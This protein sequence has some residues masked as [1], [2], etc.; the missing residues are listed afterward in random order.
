MTRTK[1]FIIGFSLSAIILIFVATLFLYK[2]IVKSIPAEEG[3][4]SLNGL[5]NAVEI[6][7]NDYGIPHIFS[8]N[9]HDLFFALGYCTA[10]DRLWQM[11][12]QRRIAQ[13]RLSEIFGEETIDLDAYMRSVGFNRIAS[14]LEKSLPDDTRS[15]LSAYSD[16]V[17]SFI[18]LNRKKLQIEFDILQYEPELWE[19]A[20]SLLL[21]RLFAWQMSFGR[22]C[23]LTNSEIISKVGTLRAAELLQTTVKSSDYPNL[24]NSPYLD[25]IIKLNSFLESRFGISSSSLGNV[26]VIGSKK[27]ASGHPIIANDQHS[28]YTNPSPWYSVSLHSP[29]YDVTGLSLPGIPGVL[30]GSNGKTSWGFTNGMADDCDFYLETLD[31][32]GFSKYFYDNSW[33]NLSVINEK[34]YVK[35]S[36]PIDFTVYQ[37]NRG[38]LI[39]TFQEA[40]NS[41]DYRKENHR[42]REIT[43]PKGK[44]ISIRWTGY[45]TSDE[46]GAILQLNRSKSI[47]EIQEALK[48]IKVPVLNFVFC[49]VS[50]IG[51]MIAGMIP[52]RL[53]SD[54]SAVIAS[55]IENNWKGLE[56]IAEQT[57]VINPT[58]NY[59]IAANNGLTGQLQISS[60]RDNPSRHERIS[61][62]I[63]SRPQ[64]SLED[65]QRIQ[66]DNI[67]F[68]AKKILNAVIPVLQNK[69]SNNYHYNQIITYLNNWDYSVDKSSISATIFNTF[70]LQLLR[71]SIAD[72]LGEDLF[73]KYCS[74]P[75]SP[76]SALTKI[77][78]ENQSHWYDDISTP[79]KLEN[80]ENIVLKSMDGT[81]EFLVKNL[82]DDTK[83]WRWSALHTLKMKHILSSFDS[84]DIIFELGPFETDGNC[85]TISSGAFYY[86][87]PFSHVFGP[88]ARFSCDM[89]NPDY[90]Y[91]ITST[92]VSGQP[93]SRFYS[94][95]TKIFLNHKN[96]IISNQKE[97]ILSS[98]LH[99]LILRPDN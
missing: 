10:Q 38:A 85:S 63:N 14:Q 88:V 56:S 64:L 78:S 54:A 89:S 9:E 6:H 23:D 43:I 18:T 65:I 98:G 58:E 75:I 94:D 96:I 22:S 76:L 82:G 60:F 40:K 31:S 46:I 62:I 69:K 17:N 80:F 81:I 7:R 99:K 84:L 44:Q 55:T 57:T 8:Q 48:N 73:Q 5:I 79:E 12:V 59:L 1:K 30:I 3:T 4:I 66:Y 74:M 32:M 34:I 51:Q 33:N 2:L 67:S 37:T 29:L 16:G 47:I 50:N 36:L 35:N 24:N 61:E 70:C 13:G 95:Q 97:K 41:F 26:W 19:P 42:N 15:A 49:D 27:S 91:Q 20:H 21:L 72:E 83:N 39:S 52:V 71:N 92:G 68:C 45:E 28:F 87:K 86:N 11:D 77:I 25:Q 93:F 53:R 90:I